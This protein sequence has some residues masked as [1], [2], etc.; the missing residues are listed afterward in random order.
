VERLKAFARHEFSLSRARK[1]GGTLR[2]HYLA[3]QRQTGKP[4]AGLMGPERP[5]GSDMIWRAFLD[6]HAG[7]ASTDM[8]TAQPIPLAEIEA[9]GRMH[10]RQITPHDL[11]LLRMLDAEYRNSTAE[12]PPAADADNDWS[13]G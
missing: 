9:W 2:S 3:I 5:A 8:G 7:R 6:L 4:P 10:H 1:G 11:L 13:A 12:A